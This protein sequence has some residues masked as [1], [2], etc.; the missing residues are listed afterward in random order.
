MIKL[1]VIE[2]IFL[3]KINVIGF[4]LMDLRMLLWRIFFHLS[5]HVIIPA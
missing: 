4:G 1:W 5:I 2:G 3:P